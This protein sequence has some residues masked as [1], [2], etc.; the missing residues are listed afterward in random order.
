MINSKFGRIKTDE[1]I[2]YVVTILLLFA[3]MIIIMLPDIITNI[4]RMIIPIHMAVKTLIFDDIYEYDVE[5]ERF[6]FS[7]WFPY[8]FNI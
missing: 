2:Q 8:L 7:P 1:F 6:A 5:L 3:A 4:I